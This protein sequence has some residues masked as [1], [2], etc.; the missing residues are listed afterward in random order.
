MASKEYEK[1]VLYAI[2]KMDS[3]ARHKFNNP[4][5]IRPISYPP[6][7]VVEMP[8]GAANAIQ[9]G[10]DSMIAQLRDAAQRKGCSGTYQ[11]RV[12]RGGIGGGPGIMAVKHMMRE[13]KSR[14][15]RGFQVIMRELEV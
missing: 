3:N 14:T 6:A 12:A 9:E 5:D 8:L 11:A 2:R 10:N 13:G 4:D 15:D 7:V 1:I